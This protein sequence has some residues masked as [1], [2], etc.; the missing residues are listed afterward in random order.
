METAYRNII[1]SFA[2]VLA[3]LFLGFFKNYFGLFPH[4]SGISAVKHFHAV[5][6]LL[7]F[8]LL[9]IQPV[10]IKNKQIAWHRLLGKASY[11]LVPLIGISTYFLA[12]AEYEREIKQFPKNIALANFI[13]FNGGQLAVFLFLYGL[14]IINRKNT[15]SHVRYMIATSLVLMDPGLEGTN[16]L[17]HKHLINR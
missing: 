4:F 14:A 12:L 16:K 6:F 7:W 13:I 8:A 17:V 3:V 10:L 2:G 9:I 11:F 1:F 5:F 15:P